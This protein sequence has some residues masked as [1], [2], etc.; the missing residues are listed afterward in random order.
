MKQKHKITRFLDKYLPIDLDAKY[1]DTGSIMGAEDYTTFQKNIWEKAMSK[2]KKDEGHNQA[3]VER[4]VT[5]VAY[6]LRHK[7]LK[8]KG[9]RM[10][11]IGCGFSPT[12]LHF[13]K[14]GMKVSGIDISKTAIIETK[15]M[16]KRNGLEYEQMIVGDIYEPPDK[17]FEKPF[18][19]II[20]S[21][22]ISILLPVTLQHVFL[23]I[24]NLLVE[25][26][27]FI[28]RIYSNTNFTIQK[29]ACIERGRKLDDELDTVF[30]HDK[31]S[32]SGYNITNI[33]HATFFPERTLLHFLHKF[34][35]ISIT[36]F[37]YGVPDFEAKRRGFK[38]YNLS[39]WCVVAE[40]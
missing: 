35:E 28:A 27:A 38:E 30:F 17:L 19:I 11:E 4:L 13:A 37:S 25:G 10:L 23:N 24:Y 21:N 14:L 1:K 40:K 22:V 33:D 18:D 5:N 34:K 32:K 8:P 15:K 7:N 9:L 31:K 29:E 39:F 36:P 6:Y 20:E 2:A 3:P 16:F 12:L 26:G